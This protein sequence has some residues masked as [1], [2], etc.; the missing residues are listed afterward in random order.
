VAQILDGGRA[1]DGGKP[2]AEIRTGDV[3][4]AN[5]VKDTPPMTFLGR[6]QKA[7][8]KNTVTASKATW[9]VWGATNGTLD[10]RADPQN[11]PAGMTRPWPGAGYAIM[12]GADFAGCYTERAELYDH[13]RQAGVTGFVTV[14]GDRHSFWAGYAAKAL[15]PGKF[16]PVGLSFITGSISAPGAGEALEHT[17]PKTHP[18]RQLFVADRDGKPTYNLNAT[19]RHGVRSAIE[20]ARSGDAAKARALSNPDLAPHLT[21][22]DVGGHGYS[23]VTASADA[24]QTEFVCIPRPISRATTPDGGPLRYRIVHR[25]ARW[26]AGEAPKLEHRLIEGDVGMSI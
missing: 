11:L 21:F 14:S 4:M 13:V 26:R 24:I 15:P 17:M 6:V 10:E 8:L 18:L 2:P 16:E 23:V 1:Y 9:K 7:W 20:Y 22:V 19:V 25:A 12:G 5:F 3:T